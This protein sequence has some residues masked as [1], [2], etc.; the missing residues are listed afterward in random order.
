M[1]EEVLKV[2]NSTIMNFINA[3][4][5]ARFGGTKETI[6]KFIISRYH[7]G[8]FYFD[9]PME[10]SSETIYKFTGIPNKGNLVPIGMKQGLFEKIMGTP[11]G[12]NSKGLI[13][14]KFQDTTPKM[15]AKIVSTGLTV[16]GHG[17]DL[18]LEMLDAVDYI[19][20]TGKV[21]HWAQ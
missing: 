2:N 1:I 4:L 19:A 10:I 3:P 21:Y 12:K 18:K 11:T 15:V 16:T 14:G 8:K 5:I 20:S 13:I 9:T 6:F 17:C 7:K